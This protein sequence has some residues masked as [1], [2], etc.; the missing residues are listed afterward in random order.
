MF[1]PCEC[2]KWTDVDADS[3]IHAQRIVDV[4]RV[5]N[6][7]FL[8]ASRTFF[9]DLNSVRIKVDAPGWAFAHAQHA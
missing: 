4:K 8:G 6:I 3:A 5:K 9:G 2:I 7:D 1:I